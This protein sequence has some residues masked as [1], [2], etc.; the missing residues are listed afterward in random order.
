MD[1]STRGSF[2]VPAG[3]LDG[4]GDSECSGALRAGVVD[5]EVGWVYAGGG[6][7]EGSVAD[8]EYDEIGMK[9]KTV[10]SAFDGE[11]VADGGAR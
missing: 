2:G 10:L 7:V 8:D 1:A 9:L 3:W 4:A 5:G 11:E 6:I